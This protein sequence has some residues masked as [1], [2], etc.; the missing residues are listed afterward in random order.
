MITYVYVMQLKAFSWS[1]GKVS[2]DSAWK[3][4]SKI[5]N[6]RLNRSLNCHLYNIKEFGGGHPTRKY[7][8]LENLKSDDKTVQIFINFN[9]TLWEIEANKTRRPVISTFEKRIFYN[10]SIQ[11]LFGEVQYNIIMIC[12]TIYVYNFLVQE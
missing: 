2:S 3:W 10:G 12:D 5:H 8:I 1:N 9:N 7:G 11:R 4:I 6:D